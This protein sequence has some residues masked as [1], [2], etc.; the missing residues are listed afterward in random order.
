MPATDG[1]TTIYDIKLDQDEDRAAV[2][3]QW[4]KESAAEQ[5]WLVMFVDKQ[6][7]PPFPVAA[8]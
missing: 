2:R 5:D 3:H 4:A 1:V 7:P 8:R 6:R